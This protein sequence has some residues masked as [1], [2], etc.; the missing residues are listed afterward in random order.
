M[1]GSMSLPPVYATAILSSRTSDLLAQP[2][3]E[4]ERFGADHSPATCAKRKPDRC[5]LGVQAPCHATVAVVR[6]VSA[7]RDTSRTQLFGRRVTTKMQPP[8]SSIT[9]VLCMV[10]AVLLASTRMT[11]G[12]I[13]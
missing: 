3:L 12:L 11:V 8:P 6:P 5:C 7:V 10:G 9:H 2:A 4:T 1:A 13:G